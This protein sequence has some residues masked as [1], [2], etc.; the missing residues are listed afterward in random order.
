[1]SSLKFKKI[2][3]SLIAALILLPALFSCNEDPTPLGYSLVQDTVDIFAVSTDDRELI[4]SS[5]SYLFPMNYFNSG[6][7]LIGKSGETE[8][9][10]LVR[11][12]PIP[13]TLNYL[14]IEDI[15]SAEI[16]LTPKRYAIGDTLSSNFL[17]FGI[18]KVNNAW[19]R[20]TSTNDFF[21]GS[22][23]TSTPFAEYS[24]RI[25]R[26]DTM[27]AI[28]LPFDKSLLV[29]WFAKQAAKTDT[30]W[31]IALVPKDNS[32]IIN[33][34]YGSSSHVR[35]APYI[36][37]TY[38]NKKGG[39][40]TLIL[41]SALEKNFS[42]TTSISDD[43]L[44]VQGA[45]SYRTRL[46]FDLS[47]IPKFAGIHKAELRLTMDRSKSSSGN[48][49]LDTVIRLDYYASEE[50]EFARQA[51]LLYYAGYREPTKDVFIVP[52]ITSA[53][54]FWN[55]RDVKG[56]F[57]LGFDNLQSQYRLN[58]LAFHKPDDPDITK[59]PKL[60]VIYSVLK[61]KED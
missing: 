27:D 54:G 50:A 3:V 16:T 30:I 38:N 49:P 25:E 9:G 37:L 24:D 46:E 59:R 26:K 55:R 60:T 39:I 48:F 34:F 18:H 47:F 8:S 53:I 52:S 22:L 44:I 2:S 51:S 41:E 17:S 13:D 28:K 58:R 57:S 10:V 32:T 21:S 12:G 42:K 61:K 11:F 23:F 40:D 43:R 1:M 14:K 5:K 4:S 45:V 7:S 35:L 31:G 15:H 19:V 33:E 20:E 56:T 29:E 36:T 6:L